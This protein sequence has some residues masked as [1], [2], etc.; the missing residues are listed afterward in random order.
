MLLYHYATEKFDVLETPRRHKPLTP[1][2]IKTHEEKAAKRFAVGL[3]IDHI[4]FFI[5]PAPLQILGKLYMG[6]A[7]AIW[8]PGRVFYEHV[9]DSKTIGDFKFSVDATPTDLIELYAFDKKYKSPTSAQMHQYFEQEAK[10]KWRAGEYGQNNDDFEK[11]AKKFVGTTEQAYFDAI[12][13][14]TES[15]WGHYAAMVVHAKIYPSQGYCKLYRPPQ[16]VVVGAISSESH[17]IIMP[18]WANW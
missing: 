1:D 12:P 8:Q 11:V 10:R 15:N 18:T 5:E 17:A 4:S 7:N 13:H 9:V 2:E 3:Y 16:R 6:H 14:F